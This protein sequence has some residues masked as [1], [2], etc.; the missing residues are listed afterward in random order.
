MRLEWNYFW[1]TS[2]VVPDTINEYPLWSMLFADLHA[3]LL[4]LPLFLLVAASALQLVRAHTTSTSG[5]VKRLMCALVLGFS[6]AIQALTNAWD[7]PLFAGLLVLI[8]L[9]TF[10]VDPG[11]KLAA[12]GRAAISLLVAAGSAYG[13]VRPLWVRGG[14]APGWGRNAE[15]GARGV[16]VLTHFGLFFFLCFVWWAVSQ[17]QRWARRGIGPRIRVFLYAGAGLVIAAGFRSADVLCAV[18]ILLFL[19]AL[20]A[21]AEQPE[22]RLAFGFIATAFF[23][24][25]FAQ[26]L[27][28]YDRMNT[29]FKLYYEA[30]PLL[31]LA[32]AVL[33]FRGP[34]HTGV[35]NH[36]PRVL[37]VF[38]A[39]LL[40]AAGFTSVTAIYGGVFAP[41][42]PSRPEGRRERPSLD[43]LRYLE[44]FR[45]A[46][47]RAVL[48]LRRTIAGTPVILEAQGNSYGDF[49]R[50]S[51][52]TGLP[53]VL[54]WEHHVKQRGNP[55]A[56]VDARRQAVVDIY[57]S[58]DL[59]KAERLLRRYHVGY[60]YVGGLEK[61]TYGGAGL[62]KFDITPTLFEKVYSNQD[63][64][65]FRVVGGDAQ[66]VITPVKETIPA[67]EI[68]AAAP[69]EADVPPDIHATAEPGQPPFFGMKE[70]RGAA[71]DHRG[72]LWV[73]DFG[74]SR[75][76]VFDSMGGS[77]GGWGGRGRGTF[78]FKELCG[79]AIRND[80]VYVAD[81]WN[82]RIQSFSLDGTWLATAKE[83]FGPRG[84]AAAPE[85]TVWV[86]DTGNKRLVAYDAGLGKVQTLGHLG[87]GPGEFSDPVGVAVSRAGAIYVADAG[88]QRI[89]MLDKS[90]RFI[91]QISISGWKMG[92]EP[93]LDADDDGTL[94]ATNPSQNTVLQLDPSGALKRTITKDD[95]GQ[96][97]SRPT[98]VA[99]D[100]K[101][102]LLY[103]INSGNNRVSKIRM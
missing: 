64:K 15:A 60:V 20:L 69:E 85:G 61:E 81:T 16:D 98:G 68:E 73:A 65:I 93:Y 74:N 2:R 78:G 21:M 9:L 32:T 28:I 66:D 25:L 92:D 40:V 31:A 101:N 11:R 29:F 91:R 42:N 84:V 41:N 8:F 82:G 88:N 49:S 10:L 58:M 71:F 79:V 6:M 24:T 7:V 14:G 18:G 102:R 45:P 52:L 80:L 97:F 103:V 96:K 3:H 72:R 5:A 62:A 50:I 90:G 37:R 87:S 13:F 53:T 94:Y 30:W 47:Y 95:E 44:K 67:A 4:A 55:E 1:A 38:F 99:I 22:D 36:W 77:L 33:V 86:A 26:R 27:F 63:V 76:R 12:L 51:M 70:P 54:G 100:H 23:L 19:F 34:E 35:W 17:S 43:G 57:K 56:E 83:L 59:A 48:W 89:Q 39:I 75:L 46:E